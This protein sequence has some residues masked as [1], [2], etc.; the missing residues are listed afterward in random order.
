MISSTIGSDTAIE[1]T[2]PSGTKSIMMT[3]RTGVYASYDWGVGAP[4]EN[5]MYQDVTLLSN[6]FYGERARGTWTIRVVDTNGQAIPSN[7]PDFVFVN[8]EH[9][10][11]LDT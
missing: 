9:H 10:S 5:N 7:N 6:A 11:V 4:V 3:P 1:L 2:S 8:N